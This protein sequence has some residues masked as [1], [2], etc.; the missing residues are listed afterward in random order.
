MSGNRDWA[1]II[2]IILAIVFFLFWIIGTTINTSDYD[3][4]KEKYNS[5]NNDCTNYVQN[6]NTTV[7]DSVQ[8]IASV[9]QSQLR[10]LQNQWEISFTNL[11][12]CYEQGTATCK[13]Q[14]PTL[15]L[16]G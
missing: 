12:N 7:N 6:S 10:N 3:V 5:L 8:I 13:Y 16:T 11:L 1:K 14:K 4:L 2:A 15:N 9:C